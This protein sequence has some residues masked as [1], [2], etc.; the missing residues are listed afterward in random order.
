MSEL[1]KILSAAKISPSITIQDRILNIQEILGDIS[2]V[3][4]RIEGTKMRI[5]FSE[6]YG[7]ETDEIEQTLEKQKET[8]RG[9]KNSISLQVY[10][11]NKY[12]QLEY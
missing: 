10:A 8:L 4:M 12:V 6:G 9:L 1:D 7:L 5:G 11:L 3:E 2:I